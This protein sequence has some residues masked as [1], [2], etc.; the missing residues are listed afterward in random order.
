MSRGNRGRGSSTAPN[1]NAVLSVGGQ[2]RHGYLH[3]VA[4][5]WLLS[6]SAVATA[7]LIAGVG[8]LLGT[9]P[10]PTAVPIVR[11]V[12]E[13]PIAVLVGIGI[14]CMISLLAWHLV[15]GQS[16][17]A[18]HPCSPAQAGAGYG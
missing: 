14:V 7:Q 11:L 6:L 18:V 15:R 8:V 4:H 13:S 12:H 1:H 5:F 16:R 9:T 2:E 3:N 17:T 10:T